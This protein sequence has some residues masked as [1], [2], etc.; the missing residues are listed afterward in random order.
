[1]TRGSPL[2]AYRSVLCPRWSMTPKWILA[3]KLTLA[4]EERL[5]R[6]QN[7][8]Q[9]FARAGNACFGAAVSIVDS[10]G[11]ES[12][13]RTLPLCR[14]ARSRHTKTPFFDTMYTLSK[15]GVLVP[16]IPADKECPRDC[17][18]RRP[19]AST[20]AVPTQIVCLSSGSW[21]RYASRLP[22]GVLCFRCI[23]CT[24]PL[25][26]TGERQIRNIQINLRESRTVQE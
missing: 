7:R 22:L 24:V 17:S 12:N 21:N 14:S 4:S 13:M 5:Q 16:G 15:N 19:L 2:N 8:S 20:E 1:M 18:A 3:L 11:G 9:I 10:V 26:E 25:V 23:G 6:L